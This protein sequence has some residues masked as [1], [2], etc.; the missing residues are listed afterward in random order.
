MHLTGKN[1]LDC[2][3]KA[4]NIC[5]NKYLWLL[6]AQHRF[7]P[8]KT[9]WLVETKI[10][11]KQRSIHP[12]L[13]YIF[14]RSSFVLLRITLSEILYDGFVELIGEIKQKRFAWWQL[15]HFCRNWGHCFQGAEIISKSYW[16]K[17]PNVVNVSKAIRLQSNEN[18]SC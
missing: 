1:I 8:Y 13:I 14:W 15:F 6:F 18:N 12:F 9:K 17:C 2:F 16:Y 10:L 7:F 4:C 5:Y 3:R 11:I